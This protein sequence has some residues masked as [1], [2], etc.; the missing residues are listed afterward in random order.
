MM[1]LKRLFK[2]PYD[3]SLM[4][5]LVESLRKL[6]YRNWDEDLN[7]KRRTGKLASR[8]GAKIYKWRD[9]NSKKTSIFAQRSFQF[10]L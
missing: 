9:S 10:R 5:Y 7:L 3:Q 6:N 4:T 1:D 8:S 2:K